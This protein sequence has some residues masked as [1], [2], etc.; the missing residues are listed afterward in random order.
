[1]RLYG[2]MSTEFMRDTMRTPQDAPM[3]RLARKCLR[4]THPLPIAANRTARR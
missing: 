1:M 2:G 4:G 3:G